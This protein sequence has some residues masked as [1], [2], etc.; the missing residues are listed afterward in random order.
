MFCL[1]FLIFFLFSLDLSYFFS[2]QFIYS[3][4]FTS[5]Y[6][7]SRPTCP[8]CIQAQTH[9]RAAS[10]PGYTMP[11]STPFVR[12]LG[13]S[14]SDRKRENEK[15]KKKNER[16]RESVGEREMEDR[17]K[18]HL[19]P[20]FRIREWHSALFFHLKLSLFSALVLFF[21]F[22]T[23]FAPSPLFIH[24]HMYICYTYVRI[25]AHTYSLSQAFMMATSGN[26]NAG[27]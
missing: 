19:S 21:L 1:S 24:T 5:T 3:F 20:F 8:P 15:K 26:S 16:E 27:P 4:I 22:P 14:C 13:E 25:H 9:G 12:T 10:S 18:S 2:S 6:F 7:L 23:P 17:C 11:V